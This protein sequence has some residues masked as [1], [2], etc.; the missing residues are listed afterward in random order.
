VTLTGSLLVHGNSSKLGKYIADEIAKMG[1]FEVLY[2][3]I[4][5]IPGAAWSLKEGVETTW[6]LY[7]VG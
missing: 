7:D 1:I 5:G 3:G 4:G 2:D 6:T